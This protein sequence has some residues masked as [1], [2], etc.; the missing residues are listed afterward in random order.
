MPNRWQRRWRRQRRRRRRRRIHRRVSHQVHTLRL[1]ALQRRVSC[2][3]CCQWWLFL[4]KVRVSPPPP[5][6]RAECRTHSHAPRS[7]C[8]QFE[9]ITC[10]AHSAHC[11]VCVSRECIS[12]SVAR[13]NKAIRI[14]KITKKEETNQSLASVCLQI[15]RG[16]NWAGT[17]P[18]LTTMR[19]NTETA[20][21]RP[22]GA[23]SS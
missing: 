16:Q 19:M 2:L 4:L 3:C 5:R 14:D 23:R 12:S 17:S 21:G 11:P 18:W 22:D 1:L 13:T 9:V 8:F 10:T 7:H 6:T 20:R 15:L